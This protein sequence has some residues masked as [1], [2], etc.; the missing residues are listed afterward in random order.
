M[1]GYGIEET[2]R[3]SDDACYSPSSITR[4]SSRVTLKPSRKIVV[5]RAI[6][7]GAV[8]PSVSVNGNTNNWDNWKDLAAVIY[9]EVLLQAVQQIG[10][11]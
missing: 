2:Y 8:C 10:R 9:C 11:I 7:P 1:V 6:W 5:K 4:I 3:F